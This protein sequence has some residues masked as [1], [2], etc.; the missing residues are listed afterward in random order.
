MCY[1]ESKV[2]EET[3]VGNTSSWNMSYT[4]PKPIWGLGLAFRSELMLS[5][6]GWSWKLISPEVTPGL[7]LLKCTL[8]VYIL[9]VKKKEFYTCSQKTKVE[10]CLV[11]HMNG[12]C[13]VGC[14]C[15]K[16]NDSFIEHLPQDCLLILYSLLDV[17]CDMQQSFND[18]KLSHLT[19]ACVTKWVST[20]NNFILTT[21]PHVLVWCDF[22]LPRLQSCSLAM[23]GFIVLALSGR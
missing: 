23:P 7:G 4:V 13:V 22:L 21:F 10:T 15:K 18:L 20:Y 12:C 8:S 3:L 6:V 11:S 19:L 17:V 1:F 2:G 16:K 9:H 14:T 5:N